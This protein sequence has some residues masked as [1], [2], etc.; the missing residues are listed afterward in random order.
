MIWFIL[1]V[2]VSIIVT[3][4][5]EALYNNKILFNNETEKDLVQIFSCMW[6]FVLL[7][8]PV[9]LFCFGLYKLFDLVIK[10]FKRGNKQ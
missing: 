4:L 7:F 5:A 6:G 9:L 2:L 3:V 8:L 1:Y 10:K